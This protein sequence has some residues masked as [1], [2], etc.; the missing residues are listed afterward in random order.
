MYADVFTYLTDTRLF[1]KY[2]QFFL[3][4]EHSL[5]PCNN[6]LHRFF[7]YIIHVNNTARSI[8]EN[9]KLYFIKIGLGMNQFVTCRCCHFEYSTFQTV[10]SQML[11]HNQQYQWHTFC[12]V[13][14][15][16]LFNCLRT[17]IMFDMKTLQLCDSQRIFI[18]LKVDTKEQM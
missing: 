8:S 3:V 18:M 1:N 16:E 12:L 4:S 9:N 10:L 6:Y 14:I 15:D 7:Q 17:L 5:L 13:F 11:H 2:M